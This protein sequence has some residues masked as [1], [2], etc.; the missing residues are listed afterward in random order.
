M[1]DEIGYKILERLNT[2]IKLSALDTLK[3]KESQEQIKILSNIGLHPKEIA[4]ILGKS[5]NNVRV[6]LTYIKK[7]SKKPSASKV[8]EDIG[9]KNEQPRDE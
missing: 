9:E 2:L 3:D 8:R 4:E 6:M 1:K 5:P 7:K